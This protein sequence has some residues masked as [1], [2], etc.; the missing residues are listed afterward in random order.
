MV[1]CFL[2]NYLLMVEIFGDFTIPKFLYFT[3]IKLTVIGMTAALEQWLD[4]GIPFRMLWVEFLQV[5]LV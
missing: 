1:A 5:E 2:A 4:P 3:Y